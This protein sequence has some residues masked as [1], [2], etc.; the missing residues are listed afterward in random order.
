[1]AVL[2]AAVSRSLLQQVATGDEAAIRAVITTYRGLI[3]SI[4]RRFEPSDVEDAVQ[5]VF[6]DIWKHAHRFDPAISTEATFV[7]MIARRRVIDRRRRQSRRDRTAAEIATI[8]VEAPPSPEV[9]AEAAMVA[10]GMSQL[11]PDQRAVLTLAVREGLTH[12][13]IATRLAM[14]LG[15]VKAHA[16]R[17]LI[18]MRDAANVNGED[19]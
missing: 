2:P 15:T 11:S 10:R 3:W 18:A 19:L 4:A 13:E 9:G 5:D 8:M 16:R 7:A 6:L 12:T 14:P 17:G 1:M